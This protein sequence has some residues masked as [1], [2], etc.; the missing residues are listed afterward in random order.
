MFKRQICANAKNLPRL[1][2]TRENHSHCSDSFVKL[3]LASALIF[4]IAQ[5][6]KFASLRKRGDPLANFKKHVKD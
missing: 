3:F 5:Q 6:K 4:R 2:K 1:C